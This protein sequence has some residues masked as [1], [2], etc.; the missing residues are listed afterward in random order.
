M[1]FRIRKDTEQTPDPS[2]R[3]RLAWPTT[4]SRGFAFAA[5]SATEVLRAVADYMDAHGLEP[6]AISLYPSLAYDMDT[7]WQASVLAV[8]M[9]PGVQS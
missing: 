4:E 3:R 5:P 8:P 1:N 9:P 7:G 2:A 6:L